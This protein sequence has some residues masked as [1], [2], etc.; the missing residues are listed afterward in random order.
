MEAEAG[1]D[2]DVGSGGEGAREVECKVSGGD[3]GRNARDYLLIFPDYTTG[4]PDYT[5]AGTDYTTAG[6]SDADRQY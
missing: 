5:T 3:A 1:E 6:R 4:H 2:G